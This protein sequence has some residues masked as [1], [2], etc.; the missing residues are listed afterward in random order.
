MEA[1]PL[2]CA[3]AWP[4]RAPLGL[5]A[6]RLVMEPLSCSSESEPPLITCS[7]PSQDRRR[8]WLKGPPLTRSWGT[9]TG[10]GSNLAAL[11]WM[12]QETTGDLQAGGRKGR[13]A[14]ENAGC[15]PGLASGPRLSPLLC[16]PC[17]TTCI[18]RVLLEPPTSPAPAHLSPEARA[19]LPE[20]RSTRPKS[21]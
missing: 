10:L 7:V 16:C 1:P 8:H 9:F 19:L 3:L 17:R 20:N 4:C 6:L 2:G 18:S 12:K 14:R 11:D 5:R 15:C 21:L 13:E